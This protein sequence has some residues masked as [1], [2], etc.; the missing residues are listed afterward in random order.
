MICGRVTLPHFRYPLMRDKYTEIMKK[1]DKSR[2]RAL[3]LDRP[4]SRRDFLN[5][6]AIGA[7]ALAYPDALRAAS[8]PAAAQDVPGYYPPLLTGMRGSHPGSF[9]AAHA[10][11]DGLPPPPP[12]DTG[13]RYDLIIVGA[14]IAG[15]PLRISTARSA[16]PAAAFSCSTTTMI[17]A[18]TRSATIPSGWTSAPHE[19]RHSTN[20]QPPAL[21][22]G[23]R[24]TAEDLGCDV[25]S[26]VK[27]PSI[28]STTITWGSSRAILRSRD[29]RRRPAHRRH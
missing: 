22:A 14:G 1:E 7:A 26:L 6:I 18:V 19:R 16:D 15:S 3:G 4:I 2:D 29:V 27:E 12:E 23:G 9:E 24:G 13:E 25:P 28:C 17:S 10:L 11:R 20:R 21:R 5:G 8:D